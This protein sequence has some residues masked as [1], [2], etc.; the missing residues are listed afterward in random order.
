MWCATCHA[1]VDFRDPNATAVIVEAEASRRLTHVNDGARLE[2]VGLGFCVAVRLGLGSL[3]V[4]A[5]ARKIDLVCSVCGSASL[6]EG[7][8]E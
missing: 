5:R 6:R 1:L 7:E 8:P 4:P 2:F 3:A